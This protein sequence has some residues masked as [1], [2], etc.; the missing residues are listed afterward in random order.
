MK[1]YVCE[2]LCVFWVIEV[3]F[4]CFLGKENGNNGRIVW[5]VGKDDE[6]GEVE[7]EEEERWRGYEETV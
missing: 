4:L 7:G 1:S 3:L 2:C 5:K 6:G